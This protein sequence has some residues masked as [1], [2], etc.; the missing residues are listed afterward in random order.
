VAE[1]SLGYLDDV[2]RLTM[3]DLPIPYSPPLEARV[4]PGPEQIVS[5]VE[6]R[7]GVLPS[8]E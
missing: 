8:S 6:S 5:A 4:L 1:E 7:L 3:P 2:S